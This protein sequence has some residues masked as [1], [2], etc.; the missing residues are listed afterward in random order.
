MTK[1][2]YLEE[3]LEIIDRAAGDKSLSTEDY[4]DLCG[5]IADDAQMK[6]KAGKTDL[7]EDD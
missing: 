2:E 1:E 5:M 4:V 7:G 6:Y 3:V